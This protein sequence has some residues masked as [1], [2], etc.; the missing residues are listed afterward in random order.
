M[1]GF[2]IGR[3]SGSRRRDPTVLT[4]RRDNHKIAQ[5]V[6]SRRSRDAPPWDLK[7]PKTYPIPNIHK[8]RKAIQSRS[9]RGGTATIQEQ[10]LRATIR[11]WLYASSVLFDIP[12]GKLFSGRP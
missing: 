10:A 7:A 8:P 5:G 6:A 11:E 12:L 9:C 1:A 3:S 4:P 2:C